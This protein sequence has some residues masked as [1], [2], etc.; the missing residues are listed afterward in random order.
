M[1]NKKQILFM[2]QNFPGQYR[3]LAPALNDD[4]RFDVSALSIEKNN[5]S[6]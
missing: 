2:H 5:D 3:H 6:I 1:S 4:K